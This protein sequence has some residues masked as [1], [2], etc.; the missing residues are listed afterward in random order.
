MALLVAVAGCGGAVNVG[1]GAG[2]ASGPAMLAATPV[3]APTIA[4][5][6]APATI[7][8]GMNTVLSVVASG[9][10]SAYQWY[11][12]GAAIS[13]ATAPVYTAT[14]AG[15]YEVVV[16]NSG[17]AVVSR[18]ATVTV[19]A[20]PV[21]VVQPSGAALAEGASH[22]LRVEADGDGLRYQWYRD[23]GAI[24]G[25]TSSRYAA[26]AAGAYAVM[27]SNAAGQASSSLARISVGAVAGAPAITAGPRSLSVNS[28]TGASFS[29]A[30]D[31]AGLSYQWYK[32]GVALPGATAATLD[33]A[34][35]TA[36]SAGSYSLVVANAA[37][38]AA[39]APA[40]LSVTVLDQG[41]N[42][43]TVAAA[44][45]SFLA[46]L[47][48]DRRTPAATPESSGTVLFDYS[49]ASTGQ[50]SGLA[51]RRHGLGLDSGVLSA[52]Q[53]AAAD[54]AIAAALDNRGIRLMKAVRRA[55]A[56][57]PYSIAFIGAPSASQPWVL[58]LGGRNLSYNI[59]YNTA[60]PGATPMYAA[61]DAGGWSG[62]A[63]H[64]PLEAQRAAMHQLA[65]AIQD[66][67]TAAAAARLSAAV[68]SVLM[69]AAGAAG[70][71]NK[72]VAYPAEER[73]V[74]YTALG[75]A[76]Q[77]L[78]KAAIETWV[79]TQAGDVAGALL[80]VYESESA[81]SSTYVAYGVGRNGSRADFRAGAN[82]A[83]ANSYLRIDGP[84]VW[85]EFI[86]KAGEA[87]PSRLQ[88]QGLWRDK[89][90]DYGGGF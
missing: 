65:E 47:E 9:A 79:N 62:G 41:A 10:S 4:T 51:G 77:A 18:S 31:G 68:S 42:T 35:A 58:Q 43:A 52:A 76:Q 36:A 25:A 84:R 83:S 27:V 67:S 45:E 71:T 40:T 50:I 16:S 72:N 74:P 32:D 20:L 81:L 66:D 57:Y 80:S 13:G 90:A 26:S 11:R 89:L 5:Q 22:L 23:G 73:G 24:A 21:I 63:R 1:S 33:I 12:D 7:A 19:T 44:A 64:A 75:S 34:T 78:V 39:S 85:L 6:P 70:S 49:L 60:Q 46:T 48:P 53:L 3:A 59:S 28:G 56:A 38:S 87:D 14:L 2:E 30:A 88:Y 69:G 55:D 61:A 17:G 54:N 82:A 8:S 37:G 86:V 15:S 29:V